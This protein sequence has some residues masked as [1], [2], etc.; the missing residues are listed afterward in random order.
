MNDKTDLSGRLALVTGAS[1]GIGAAVA[2]ALAGAG[3][4]VILVARTVGGLESVD[5]QIRAAGGQATLLPMDLLKL[6]EIDKLGPTIAERFGKLDIFVGNAG[7]TGTLT[8][9]THMKATE[10]QKVIDLNVNANFRLIRTLDPLLQASDAGRAIFVTSG[11]GNQVIQAFFGAYSTSKAA[12]SALVKTYAAETEKTNLRVNLVRPG[13]IETAL[14]AK[15]YPGG[16][17][18]KTRKPDDI[19][20]AFVELASPVCTRHGELIDLFEE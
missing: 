13:V 18:G 5:D 4:H 20:P 6:D 7:M 17:P 14:L 12:V 10:W 3:A 9:V 2:R 15:A 1:R 11:M 16:Y 8:P 19:A